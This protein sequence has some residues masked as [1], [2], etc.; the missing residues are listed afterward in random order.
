MLDSDGSQYENLSV[1][2]EP[3]QPSKSKKAKQA[4]Q[5]RGGRGSASNHAEGGLYCEGTFCPEFYYLG[6]RSR[7]QA[8]RSCREKTSF[9]LYHRL[10]SMRSLDDMPPSL[11]LFVVYRASNGKHW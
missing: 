8:E 4:G 2:L 7:R 3:A 10:P 1:V 11:H 5:V 6:P 9:R